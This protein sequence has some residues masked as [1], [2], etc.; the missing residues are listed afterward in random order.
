MEE[1]YQQP[2]FELS[3]HLSS[4]SLKCIW[5]QMSRNETILKCCEII[6]DPLNQQASKIKKSKYET[7]VY[8][9]CKR[10]RNSTIVVYFQFENRWTKAKNIDLCCRDYIYL[11]TCI[12]SKS[13]WLS[14]RALGQD[15]FTLNFTRSNTGTCTQ[16]KQ[17]N[18]SLDRE[19]P[20][21]G[22][23]KRRYRYTLSTAI[24]EMDMNVVD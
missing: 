21:N 22:D 20:T 3:V 12:I 11:S 1:S 9:T 15:I 5:I 6:R 4:L 19:I 2:A 10:Y 18:Y 14:N 16:A 23:F 17:P 8:A 13:S 7:R 24:R